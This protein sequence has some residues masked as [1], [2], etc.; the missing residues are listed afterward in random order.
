MLESLNAKIAGCTAC[1]LHQGRTQTV[2]GDGDPDAELMF[3]GEA[4]GANE[5]L[6]GRPFVGRAGQLL[7]DLLAGIGLSRPQVFV[8]NVVKCRPPNNR[9]PM[10]DEIGC[11]EVYLRE[12]IEGIRPKLIVLLGRFATQYFL[13]EAKMGETRGQP[14]QAGPWLILPVYHPAAALRNSNLMETLRQ[15]FALIPPL[16]GQADRPEIAPV[17]IGHSHG[18]T[19]DDDS[20]R[21]LL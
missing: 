15:D 10:P 8:A 1:R 7:D 12:Q 4:P 5:D 16:L 3:I 21:S 14:F 9:D 19:E 2:P 11:C 18:A 13:P 17:Q 6:Q 20:Q